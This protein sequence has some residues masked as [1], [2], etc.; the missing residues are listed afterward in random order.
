M[1]GILASCTH[2]E[3]LLEEALIQSGDNRNELEKVL[4]HYALDKA[5]SLKLKAAEYLIEN[6]PGHYSVISEKLVD[7]KQQLEKYGAYNDAPHHIQAIFDVYPYQ[8]CLS[9]LR[10]AGRIEDIKIIK[11]DYL[12]NNIEKAF[13]HWQGPYGKHLTFDEFCETLLP[14]RVDIEP[15]WDWRDSL[16]TE[17]TS[18]MNWL[19]HIDEYKYSPFQACQKINDIL[20]ETT[21]EANRI[22]HDFSHPLISSNEKDWN[23]VQYVY[24]TQYVMRDLGIPVYIDYVPQYGIRGSRHYWN[25][26]LHYTG[27]NYPFHGYNHGP[28]RVLNPHNGMIKVFRFCY[29]RNR[30]WISEVAGNEPI[31]LSL[32]NPFIKDVSH[33]YQRTHDLQIELVGENA[34]KRKFAYLCVFNNEQWVPVDFGIVSGKN[35]TFHN[36]GGRVVCIAGYWINDEIIPASHPF[37]VDG[38]GNISYLIPDST[39][40]QTIGLSRKYPLVNW[41]NRNSD[42]LVGAK[43]EASSCPDFIPLVEQSVLP[44]NAYSNYCKHELPPSSKKYRYWRIK[45][46]GAKAS[47]AELEFFDDKDQQLDGC[48]FTSSMEEN[49]NF[50]KGTLSDKDKLTSAEIHDWLAIDFGVPVKVQR[51]RYLPLTDDNHISSGELYELLFFNNG[52]FKSLGKKIADSSYIR[53]DSVPSNSLYWIRDHTKGREERIFTFENRQVVFR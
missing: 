14:Y 6:M 50:K 10:D 20:H 19:S 43:I 46:P 48:Y 8:A 47:L 31:P 2:P 30:R 17:F 36:V 16:S 3:D 39:H 13:S 45:L 40:L 29:T 27:K 4:Q 41:I 34:E 32:G 24:G 7:Y 44:E 52:R 23:C 21:D 11:A 1:I 5:D 9:K 49:S 18:A 51:I 22:F 37:L 15:F 12:I 26:V 25:C 28:E 53:F 42:R 33:E 35:V 38:A